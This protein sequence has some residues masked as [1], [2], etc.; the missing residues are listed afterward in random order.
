MGVDGDDSA[1]DAA[2]AGLAQ[3]ADT[4]DDAEPSLA[5]ATPGR[6]DGH[7]DPGR[8][9]HGAGLKVDAESVLSAKVLA[10]CRRHDLR[11]S[12]TVRQ[13]KTVAAAIATISEDAWQAIDYPTAAWRRSLRPPSAATG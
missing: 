13:T 7:G 3:R 1:T 10:A 5:T 11:S 8:A 9:G 4:A 2:G 12:I 6:G